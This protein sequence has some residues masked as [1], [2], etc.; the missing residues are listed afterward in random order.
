SVRLCVSAGEALPSAI[1]ERW[2]ERFGL[3]ILDG[4]GSTEI[5]HI[6]ISNRPGMV[7]PGSSGLLVPGYEARLV[8]EEHR[9]VAPGEIGNLL[10]KG[11]STCAFY[12]NKHDRTKETIAG[13]WIATGD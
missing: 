3:E 12:W 1:F 6:F 5:L 13:H 9:D 7:R 2:R 10:V 8:D 11:D 4:I